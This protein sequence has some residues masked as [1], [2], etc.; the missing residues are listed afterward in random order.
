[1]SGQGVLPHRKAEPTP[2]PQVSAAA[3]KKHRTE[4]PRHRRDHTLHPLEGTGCQG[5]Q[6][7]GDLLT[8]G[9]E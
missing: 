9:V 4:T 5:T 1:M 8:S 3:V 7:S 2:A 6:S